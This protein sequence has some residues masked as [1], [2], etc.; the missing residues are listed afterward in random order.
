MDNRRVLVSFAVILALLLAVAGVSAQSNT[1]G[2][3]Y[4]VVRGDNLTIIAQKCGVTVEQLRAA[5][6]DVF[7]LIFP[8]QVL[9]L[10]PVANP[11]AVPPAPDLPPATGTPV[12]ALQPTSGPAS[13]VITV[14]ANGFPASAAVLVGIGR[15]G[16]VALQV[17][18]TTTAANGSFTL[19]LNVPGN[20][21][22][23]EQL[24]VTVQ[25]PD[26]SISA[27]GGPYTVTGNP[28]AGGGDAG[29]VP[30]GASINPAGLAVP[31]PPVGLALEGPLFDRVNIYLI[32]TEQGANGVL[33]GCNEVL[34]PV[35]INVPRTVAPLTAGVNSML[36][37]SAADYGL[38]ATLENPLNGQSLEIRDIVI[39][40]G[41][42]VINLTGTLSSAGVCE[43]ARLIGQL[44]ATA[45]QYVTVDQVAV[46]VNGQRFP[47]PGGN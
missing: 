21:A 40:G 38:A 7:S 2:T 39:V 18:N 41:E 13:G 5:N 31:P 32:S 4:T 9:S 33:T 43:D 20:V 16:E 25:T 29:T 15:P 6:P 30:P 37:N 27:T 46:F 12:V 34:V 35:Q 47:R 24:Y 44:E 45:L 17:V 28:G 14:V 19:S 36:R 11:T 8:G 26:A 10:V 22:L 3:E 1:C 42:A 23:N